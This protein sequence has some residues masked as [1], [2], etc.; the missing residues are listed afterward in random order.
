MNETHARV[1][2]VV[3]VFSSAGQRSYVNRRIHA[4]GSFLKLQTF[5]SYNTMAL[6]STY[7]C[8]DDVPTLY[9]I[10]KLWT[11]ANARVAP[12]PLRKMI[13]RMRMYNH[14]IIILSVRLQRR[15]T[16]STMY[17]RCNTPADG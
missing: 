13:P 9:R 4:C 15:Y 14:I 12:H 10:V 8:F 7:S 3:S 2:G 17:A 5:P 6:K 11:A 1:S 16:C